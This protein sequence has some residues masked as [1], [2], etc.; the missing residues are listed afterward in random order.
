MKPNPLEEHLESVAQLDTNPIWK[1]LS[2]IIA[3][4]VKIRTQIFQGRIMVSEKGKG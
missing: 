3:E 1:E 2:A 4:Q